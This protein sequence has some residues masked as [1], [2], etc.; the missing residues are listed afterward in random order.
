MVKRFQINTKCIDHFE[1]TSYM[2][3]SDYCME[4]AMENYYSDMEWERNNGSSSKNMKFK[5]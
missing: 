5:M 4:K 2:E 1:A 3:M